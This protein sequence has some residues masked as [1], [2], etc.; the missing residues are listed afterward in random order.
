MLNQTV[1]RRS[2]AQS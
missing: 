1:F 2:T